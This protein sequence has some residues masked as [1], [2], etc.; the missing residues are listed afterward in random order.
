VLQS[1]TLLQLLVLTSLKNSLPVPKRLLRTKD[2]QLNQIQQQ[3]Q[4]R[5]MRGK[6]PWRFARPE[7]VLESLLDSPSLLLDVIF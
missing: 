5:L 2:Q 4:L 7:A 3:P 6:G 1:L